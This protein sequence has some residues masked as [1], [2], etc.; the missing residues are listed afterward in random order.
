MFFSLPRSLTVR[1][2]GLFTLSTLLILGISALLLDRQLE[3][4]LDRESR[5]FLEDTVEVI[6]LV[7]ERHPGNLEYLRMEVEGET[8]AR[9]NQPTYVRVQDATDRVLAETPGMLSLLP[10]AAFRPLVEQDVA[11][12]TAPD[13]RRFYLLERW[14]ESSGGGKVRVQAALDVDYDHQRREETRKSVWGMVVFGALLAFGAGL[15]LAW[16]GLRPLRKIGKVAQQITVSRLSQRIGAESWPSELEE[17]AL[18]FDSMLERLEEAFTRISRFSDDLAHE[19]RTPLSNLRGE[20]ELALTHS[21]S[22][23]EL[24]EVLTSNLEELQRLS[25]LVEDML[26]LARAENPRHTLEPQS[27]SIQSELEALVELYTPAAEEVGVELYLEAEGEV[28]AVPD[29][30]HRA[31]GNLLGNALRHTPEGGCVVLKGTQTQDGSATLRVEDSGPGIP[32]AEVPR[33]FERFY[34]GDRSRT[35]SSAGSGLGL[36]I[37]RQIMTLHG[38]SVQVQVGSEGGACFVLVF[39]G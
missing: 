7:L 12:Y 29:L 38:G 8:A 1:L 27:L 24:R 15:V 31:V 32:E 4:L 3:R 35:Q 9:S 10:A 34:R 14:I 22:P 20:T 2:V 19:F 16:T 39:P 25:T 36:S 26:F 17:I 23:D 37:V 21:R 11:L 13:Q 18:S 28:Q 5:E 30:L 33:V 6:R